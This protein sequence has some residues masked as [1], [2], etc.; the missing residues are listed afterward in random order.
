MSGPGQ[1]DL[2]DQIMIVMEAAF[3]PQWGEAWNRRQVSDALLLNSTHS[4]LIDP[5]GQMVTALGPLA[6]GFILSRQAADEEELLLIAVKPEHRGRGL[7]RKLIRQLK[8]EANTRKVSKIFLE[9]REGNP[10]E[11]LYRSEGFETIG[12]RKNYY[13]ARDGSR[14]NA[15]TF[16]ATIK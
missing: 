3:D 9:M 11:S 15:L 12:L 13:T 1:V 6:A 14:M 8:L 10:A 4:I 7:G 5:N 2:I 16:G